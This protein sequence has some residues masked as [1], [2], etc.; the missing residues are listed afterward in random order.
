MPCTIVFPIAFLYNED[1]IG[2]LLFD[3]EKEAADYWNAWGNGKD[4]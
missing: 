2:Y 4:S 3:T 1:S